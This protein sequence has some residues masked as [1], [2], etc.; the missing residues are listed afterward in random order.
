MG[1][2]DGNVNALR[3]AERRDGMKIGAVELRVGIYTYNV[4]AVILSHFKHF[5]CN[6]SSYRYLKKK[7][8]FTYILQIKKTFVSHY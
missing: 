7:D 2:C 3:T 4:A 1:G 5:T 8:V 6:D